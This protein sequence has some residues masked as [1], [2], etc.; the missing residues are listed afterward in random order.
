MKVYTTDRRGKRRGLGLDD[1]SIKLPV[2]YSGVSSNAMDKLKTGS[3]TYEESARAGTSGIFSLRLLPARNF[4]KPLS[5]NRP[6][7]D[8]KS[9]H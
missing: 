7:E 5:C 2:K 4:Q 3:M 1:H 9:W 8:D 6:L